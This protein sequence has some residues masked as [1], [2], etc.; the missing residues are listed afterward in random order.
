MREKIIH[1]LGNIVMM[2]LSALRHAEVFLRTMI[3]VRNHT[4]DDMQVTLRISTQ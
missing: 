2:V 4:F 1:T 3:K